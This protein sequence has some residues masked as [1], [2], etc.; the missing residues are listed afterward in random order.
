M[1]ETVEVLTTDTYAICTHRPVR[2][3]MRL[4]MFCNNDYNLNEK[5]LV[6]Q[7]KSF[8]LDMKYFVEVEMC[9]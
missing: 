3:L 2:W 1:D 8:A 6:T 9:P 7:S 5:K 4:C